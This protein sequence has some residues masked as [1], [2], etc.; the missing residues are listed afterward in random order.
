MFGKKKINKQEQDKSA[1]LKQEIKTIDPPK[2][3][4]EEYAGVDQD[5]IEID[6]EIHPIHPV[7]SEHHEILE[8]EKELRQVA[9][10]KEN[11]IVLN[12]V[13]VPCVYYSHLCPIS[14]L[15]RA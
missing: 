5:G 15:D 10:G 8:G 6:E 7:G 1:E 12:S 4:E 11:H 9:A 14:F 2:S 3:I 13:V